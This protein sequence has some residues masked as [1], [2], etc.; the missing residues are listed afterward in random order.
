MTA[1][2]RLY[3]MLVPA[4]LV[5]VALVGFGQTVRAEVVHTVINA[6]TLDKGTIMLDLDGDGIADFA[7]N[8][9]FGQVSCG[10]RDGWG[11]S[12]T[13]TKRIGGGVVPSKR[14]PLLAELLPS[15]VKI[16]RRTTFYHGYIQ[17]ERSYCD[18]LPGDDSGYLGLEFKINGQT[19][20]GW[21]QVT[22]DFL[23]GPHM[24]TIVS[25]VAYET[26]PNE[27]IRTGQIQDNADA[28]PEP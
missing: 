21:A 27:G 7:L 10:I 24:A 5:L 14:L 8:S 2:Q 26:I 19:H 11:S 4:L 6:R 18:S 15:N 28:S 9:F 16:D 1:N 3:G 22:I 12:V 17:V 25:D 23:S 13:L 20:Y